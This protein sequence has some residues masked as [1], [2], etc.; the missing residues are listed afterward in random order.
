MVWPRGKFRQLLDH[1]A[2]PLRIPIASICA[3]SRAIRRL[4][5]GAYAVGGTDR[6]RP[7]V[8]REGSLGGQTPDVTCDYARSHELVRRIVSKCPGHHCDAHLRA[9]AVL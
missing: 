3:L 2:V 4:S 7:Y 9:S 5:A 1:A 8:G 6:R